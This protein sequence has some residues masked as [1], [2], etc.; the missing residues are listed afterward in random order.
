MKLFVVFHDEKK[1]GLLT[2][3]IFKINICEKTY[4]FLSNKNP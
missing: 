1:N 3:G 2:D 4:N